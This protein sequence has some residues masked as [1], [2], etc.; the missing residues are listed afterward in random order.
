MLLLLL[1]VGFF[2]FL[3][4]AARLYTFSFSFSS[5]TGSSSS[6]SGSSSLLLISPS[7]KS[8]EGLLLCDG[9]RGT[10][11]ACLLLD[12][13]CDNP[14]GCITFLILSDVFDLTLGSIGDIGFSLLTSSGS[15]FTKLSGKTPDSLLPSSCTMCPSHQPESAESL[16]STNTMSPFLNV[17][18]SVLSAS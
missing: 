11:G 1:V 18:S 6:T 4:P 15:S 12:D 5:T 2:L 17:S 13:C 7:S 10:L 3:G 8:I 16:L 14:V 9:G